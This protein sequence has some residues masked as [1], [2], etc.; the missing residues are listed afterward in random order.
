MSKDN[1]LNP[2]HQLFRD[3]CC[4]SYIIVAVLRDHCEW[5]GAQ[6]AMTELGGKKLLCSRIF[7][8]SHAGVFLLL[9]ALLVQ[10]HWCC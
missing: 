7:I 6:K 8:Y 9:S 1:L 3:Y 10:G 2:M 5:I 4:N